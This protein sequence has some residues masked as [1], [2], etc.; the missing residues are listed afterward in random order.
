MKIIFDKSRPIRMTVKYLAAP[1]KKMLKTDYS[2]AE[3]CLPSEAAG[4]PML[5]MF[6]IDGMISDARK[7]P[8]EMQEICY[9]KV[10]IPFV[11]V[12]KTE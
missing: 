10:L 2:R 1:I 11:S 3:W 4:N 7:L 12:Y 8:I 6:S 5:W 9:E